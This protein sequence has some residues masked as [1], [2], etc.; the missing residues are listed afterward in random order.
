MLNIPVI[1]CSPVKEVPAKAVTSKRAVLNDR[2]FAFG[3]SDSGS[4]PDTPVIKTK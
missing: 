2:Y 3:A 1:D 4:N